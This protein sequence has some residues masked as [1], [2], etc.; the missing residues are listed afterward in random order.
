MLWLACDCKENASKRRFTEKNFRKEMRSSLMLVTHNHTLQM[1]HRC[2]MADNC[3]QLPSR[4]REKGKSR[5]HCIITVLVVSSHR[6][7]R[8]TLW[9]ADNCRQTVR[10]SGNSENA[11]TAN[12][13]AQ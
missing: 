3:R 4:C 2:Q 10:G 13:E 11:R 5:S 6:T 12:N 1:Q 7:S 9:M 8:W